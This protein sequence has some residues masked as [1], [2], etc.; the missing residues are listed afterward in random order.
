MSMKSLYPN[1]EYHVKCF[2]CG[3]H[4]YFG[5]AKIQA[6]VKAASHKQRNP[7]HLVRLYLGDELLRESAPQIQAQLPLDMPPY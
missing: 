1:T 5:R 4:R 7:T 6:E 3:Y 2:K